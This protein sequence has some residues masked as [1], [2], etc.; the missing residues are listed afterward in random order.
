MNLLFRSLAAAS[1]L[2]PLALAAGAFAQDGA[3]AP[4]I[5]YGRLTLTG[6]ELREARFTPPFRT[7]KDG[8]ETLHQGGWHVV[9]H[10]GRFPVRALDPIL[11]LGDTPIRNYEREVH[12]ETESLRFCV[13]DPTLL[14]AERELTVIYGED[15]RTRTRLLERLDPEKLVRL[16]A[17]ER[18][19]LALPELEGLTLQTV[20]AAGK[21]TGIGHVSGGKVTLAARLDDGRLAPLPVTVAFDADGKFSLDV[22]ALPERATHLVALLL[23]GGELRAGVELANLPKGVELLDSKPIRRK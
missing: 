18:A 13:T 6:C 17:A 16:P 23:A 14:R 20:T 21:V 2:L 11:W 12:G 19:A 15:E 9:I 4:A 5:E 3:P 1:L 22:G 10:G 7:W 8:K